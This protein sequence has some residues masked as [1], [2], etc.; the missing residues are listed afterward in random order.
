VLATI[1]GVRAAWRRRGLARW[2]KLHTIRFALED[3]AAEMV[4]FNDAVNE[5]I[6]RLNASLGFVESAVEIRYRRS[7]NEARGLRAVPR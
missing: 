7:L 4:T 1:T 6:L 2:L 5:G 3:G